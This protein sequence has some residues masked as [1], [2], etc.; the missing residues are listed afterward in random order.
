MRASEFY[1]EDEIRRGEC[2]LMPMEFDFGPCPI[3]DA[4]KGIDSV[5]IERYGE[6]HNAYVPKKCVNC[7]NFTPTGECARYLFEYGLLCSLDF[8]EVEEVNI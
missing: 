5:K 4:Q 7:K 6:A 2:S 8:S 1:D 3:I